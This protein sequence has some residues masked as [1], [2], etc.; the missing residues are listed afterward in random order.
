[1]NFQVSIYTSRNTV[2]NLNC[3]PT[4]LLSTFYKLEHQ[5]NINSVSDSNIWVRI[6]LLKMNT[7][8]IHVVTENWIRYV[9]SYPGHFERSLSKIQTSDLTLNKSVQNAPDRRKRGGLNFQW[10]R[11]FWNVC[12]KLSTYSIIGIGTWLI[13]V[14]LSFSF[15]IVTFISISLLRFFNNKG[16]L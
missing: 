15:Q 13:N 16:F 12:P 1:M 8:K 5:I 9:R 4:A 3:R 14:N 11:E 10:L 2:E 7:W 6:P